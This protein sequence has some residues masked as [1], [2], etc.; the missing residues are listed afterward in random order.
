MDKIKFGSGFQL[1]RFSEP[2]LTTTIY[3][4]PKT[5]FQ[6]FDLFL[7][8]QIKVIQIKP[9]SSMNQTELSY[10]V[11]FEKYCP[12]IIHIRGLHTYKRV[13][14][15]NHLDIKEY[16]TT[17]FYKYSPFA[18]RSKKFITRNAYFSYAIGQA[19][20]PYFNH[21]SKEAAAG[22]INNNNTT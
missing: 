12:P 5:Q 2:L 4:K 15:L 22:E 3:G 1:D 21:T 7:K 10:V 9:I 14:M 17:F 16:Q 8:S 6:R 18:P 20:K 19:Q 13:F 11:L